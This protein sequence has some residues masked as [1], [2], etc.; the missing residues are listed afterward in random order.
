MN[1]VREW[2]KAGAKV[3]DVRTPGEFQAGAYPRAINIPLDEL[4][5]RQGELGQ[6][7]SRIVVYCESG[8]RSALARAFLKQLGFTKV[9]DGGAMALLP[10]PESVA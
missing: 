5:R 8:A 2:L 7:G 6:A 3:L 1:L 9:V 4:E 10:D